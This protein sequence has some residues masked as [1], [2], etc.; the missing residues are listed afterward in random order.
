MGSSWTRDGTHVSCISRWIL[1][2]WAI[3]E[4]LFFKRSL[5]FYLFIC[6]WLCCVFVA[7]CRLLIAI[8]LSCYGRPSCSSD[9]KESA[10]SAGDLG[11][12]LGLRRSPG[13]ENGSPLQYS[14]L[15]NSMDRGPGGLQSMGSQRVRHNWA[16]NSLKLYIFTS[17]GN[18]T[19]IFF[20]LEA[21][22]QSLI[23]MNCNFRVILIYSPLS[24]TLVS[25]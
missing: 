5:E 24:S 14:C 12:I 4:A 16:T 6:F 20:I 11:S 7:V 3:R 1:Y 19:M 25:K 9:S 22:F 8:G 13:E 18:Q 2:H 21:I 17:G 15:E 10:C 23:F